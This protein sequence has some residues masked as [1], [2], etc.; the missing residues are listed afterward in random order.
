ESYDTS[1]KY[2]AA[3]NNKRQLLDVTLGWHHQH[4][5]Q[6]AIDGSGPYDTLNPDLG[7]GQPRASYRQSK[8]TFHSLTD[9]ENLPSGVAA[10]ACGYVPT[11]NTGAG[12]KDPTTGMRVGAL[13]PTPTCPMPT[14][15]AGGPSFVDDVLSD[16]YQGKAVFTNLLQLAGHHVIKA[17]I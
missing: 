11:F 13:V 15:S 17:G 4:N 2:S 1:L 12:P 5:A 7:A 16:S 10:G 3:F 6:R 8:P 14:Y 9:F